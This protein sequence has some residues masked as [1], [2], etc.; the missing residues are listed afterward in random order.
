MKIHFPKNTYGIISKNLEGIF[1][2]FSQR[3]FKGILNIN[4]II[5]RQVNQKMA[6]DQVILLFLS[7]SIVL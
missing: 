5:D 4:K 3:V 1:F 7:N 6:L 2:K